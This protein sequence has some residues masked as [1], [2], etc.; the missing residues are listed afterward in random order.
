MNLIDSL[1]DEL[2]SEA[3]PLNIMTQ[4]N[5]HLRHQNFWNQIVAYEK[6][7]SANQLTP[8][9]NH[10]NSQ[11]PAIFQL[12]TFRKKVT[13]DKTAKAF[14]KA[15]DQFAETISKKSDELSELVD[16]QKEKL[17]RIELSYGEL[18]KAIGATKEEVDGLTSS[19]QTE[20]TEDQNSRKTEFSD[21][22][23]QRDKEHESWRKAFQMTAEKQLSDFK[24]ASTKKLEDHFEKFKEKLAGFQQE[25]TESHEAILELHG[26]VAGDSVGAGYLKNA[27]SEKDQANFWRGVAIAFI[28][29]TVVWVGI[30]YFAKFELSSDGNLLWGKVFKAVSLAGVLLYGAVYASKQSSF[31]RNNEKRTRWFA[32]E[33]KAI[34][35]FIASLSKDQQKVLKEKLSERLFG[36][37]NSESESGSPNVDANLVK[38]I[39]DAVRDIVK[40]K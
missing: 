38:V 30:T 17:E 29:A 16:E 18:S 10:L 11:L 14:E 33:I 15:F 3:A 20:F 8:A 12:L 7:P 19:W 32:L 35:P 39:V 23:I 28:L 6:A 34:D 5:N 26:L 22:Q 27:D 40:I 25:A 37:N 4:I 9:N 13:R 2:D 21:S 36:Q 1:R 24:A 31:H